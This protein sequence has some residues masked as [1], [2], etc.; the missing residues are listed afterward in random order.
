MYVYLFII[1]LIKLG[2]TEPVRN[3]HFTRVNV[4]HQYMLMNMAGS[5][6]FNK[7]IFKNSIKRIC[8]QSH[9]KTGKSTGGENNQCN[10]SGEIG[11]M[12]HTSYSFKISG[13][14]MA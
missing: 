6:M 10:G 14:M 1:I 11:V 12:V 2:P 4:F 5:T 8:E 3:S 7:Q 13:F 9:W